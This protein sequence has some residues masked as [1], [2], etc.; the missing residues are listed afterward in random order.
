MSYIDGF[1]IAVPTGNKQ[2]FIDHAKLGD[3]VFMELGATRILECWGDDVSDGKLTDFR[4]AVQAKDDET[5]VFSW[6]EWPDKKTRD[7]AHARMVEWM[8]NPD[9]ADPRMHPEKNP[10]PFDGKRLIFGGF[11]PLVDTA[12]QGKPAVQPYLFFRGRCEEAIAYYEQK[13]GAEVSMLMRFKD[14]PDK[15]GPDKVSPQLDNRIM[16]AEIRIKGT[17][18]MMSDGMNSGPLDFQCMSL[19]IAADDEAEVDRL[20]SALAEGGTVQMPPGKTFFSPRFG[21]VADKFGVSW[22]I[23]AQPTS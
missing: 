23:I 6:I 4:K 17:T 8:R 21:A 9:K 14:N 5:P 15:P 3:S 1:V 22:I 16:H 19:S 20:C 10:M 7:A 13:L 18:L 12:P 11:T 2:K